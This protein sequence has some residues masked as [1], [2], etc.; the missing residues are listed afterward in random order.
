MSLV[1]SPN[2][3]KVARADDGVCWDAPLGRL[4]EVVREIIAGKI[5]TVYVWV[6]QLEPVLK[7]T[8][9]GIGQPIRAGI[10]SHPLVDDDWLQRAG[11]GIRHCNRGDRVADMAAAIV[12]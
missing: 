9:G 8:I 6:E 5:E 7:Q 10:V 4:R 12:N 2:K 1:I 3:Q 11:A